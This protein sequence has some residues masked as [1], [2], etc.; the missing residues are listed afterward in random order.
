MNVIFEFESKLC[1]VYNEQTS[2]P[3]ESDIAVQTIN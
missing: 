1:F 3:D 2:E